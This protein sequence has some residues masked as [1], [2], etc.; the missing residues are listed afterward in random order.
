MELCEFTPLAAVGIYCAAFLI[1]AGIVG[2]A[3]LLLGGQRRY[4]KIPLLSLLVGII[5]CAASIALVVAG[6]PG[7]WSGNG[8]PPCAGSRSTAPLYSTVAKPAL[9]SDWGPR[10][11]LR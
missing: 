9:A 4:I 6:S 11:E 5:F 10:A 1:A 8:E 2:A 7:P 3:G